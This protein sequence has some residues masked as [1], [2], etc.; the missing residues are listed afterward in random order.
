MTPSSRTPEGFPN[1]CPICG[2]RVYVAP[3]QPAGDAPCPTCGHLLWFDADR[4]GSLSPLDR[5]IV[6]LLLNGQCDREIASELN[7]SLRSVRAGRRR[8]FEALQST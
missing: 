1:H 2:S 7:I 8:I 6:E 5:Q 4:L 3:S